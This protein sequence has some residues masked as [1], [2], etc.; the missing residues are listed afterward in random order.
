MEELKFHNRASDFLTLKNLHPTDA[1]RKMYENAGLYLVENNGQYLAYAP[2]DTDIKEY[3]DE[4]NTMFEQVEL[5][6]SIT[7]DLGNR[8]VEF[9]K[10]RVDCGIL[11]AVAE[12]MKELGWSCDT[13]ERP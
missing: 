1:E 4:L 6:E 8:T 10:S 7:F 13:A 11:L 2:V 9:G 3:P 5:R 12:R